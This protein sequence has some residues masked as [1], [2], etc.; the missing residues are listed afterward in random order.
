[1]ILSMP[2]LD[3]ATAPLTVLKR[4]LSRMFIFRATAEIRC[5]SSTA[6]V[7]MAKSWKEHL[8]SVVLVAG[9]SSLTS[10]A[11]RFGAIHL[12]SRKRRPG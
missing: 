10:H 7:L 4:R 11:I 8:A 3:R 9:L 5:C 1:M 6:L 12:I 2:S